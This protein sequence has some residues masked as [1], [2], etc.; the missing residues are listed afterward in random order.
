MYTAPKHFL[1][2]FFKIAVYLFEARG[3]LAHISAYPPWY[4]FGTSAGH[5]SQT[6]G[7]PV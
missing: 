1:G 4:L 3:N 5:V 2:T 6:I 7:R